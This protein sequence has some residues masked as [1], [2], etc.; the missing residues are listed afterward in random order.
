MLGIVLTKA[1]EFDHTMEIP[2]LRRGEFAASR[3]MDCQTFFGV[4]FLLPAASEPLT[5]EEASQILAGMVLEAWR[6]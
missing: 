1:R 2:A 6:E 5:L 3:G 4:A